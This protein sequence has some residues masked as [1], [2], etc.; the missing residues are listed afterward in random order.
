MPGPGMAAMMRAATRNSQKFV[1]TIA[2]EPLMRSCQA[3][4]DHLLQRALH[5]RGG[6]QRECVDGHVAVM[7]RATQRVLECTVLV[8][9]PDGVVEVGVADLAALQRPH[10]EGAL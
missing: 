7:L 5:W 1:S 3:E 10:P 9:Q 8:H 6:K 2:A 4:R